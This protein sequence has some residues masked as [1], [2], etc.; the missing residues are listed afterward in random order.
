MKKKL[1]FFLLPLNFC[2]GGSAQTLVEGGNFKD[3]ILPMHGS[4]TLEIQKQ[5]DPTAHI[6]GAQDVQNRYIDNGCEIDGMNLWGGN[7]Y[8][9][10][11]GKFY[12]FIAGW[13]GVKNA[14]NYWSRSHIYR[15]TSD[16]P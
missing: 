6:W 8:K 7:V 5:K 1:I 12:Q 11:N 2:I 15:V 14:F 13:D 4:V 16:N 9:E 3:R 10:V